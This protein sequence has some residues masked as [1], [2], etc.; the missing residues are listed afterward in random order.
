MPGNAWVLAHVNQAIGRK[1][2]CYLRRWPGAWMIASQAKSVNGSPRRA[3]IIHI[4]IDARRYIKSKSP[5]S[6]II[7]DAKAALRPPDRFAAWR[8]PGVDQRNTFLEI[9]NAGAQ[10]R[11]RVKRDEQYPGSNSILEAIS[12]RDRGRGDHCHRRWTTPDVDRASLYMDAP[13]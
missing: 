2:M 7:A 12:R 9:E 11:E 5:S 6:A 13:Q 8:S 1:Q 10:F 4:D 3:G